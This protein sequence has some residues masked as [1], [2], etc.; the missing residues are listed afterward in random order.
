MTA[1]ELPA[2]DEVDAAIA[3]VACPTPVDV[4]GVAA[5]VPCVGRE[6]YSLRVHRQRIGAYRDWL[7]A[8]QAAPG[9]LGMVQAHATATVTPG[10]GGGT[11]G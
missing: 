8:Q 11:G 4:C 1:A 10:E 2:D 6:G 9:V 5:T 3:N 7:A